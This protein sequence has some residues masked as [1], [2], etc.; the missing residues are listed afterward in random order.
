[1]NVGE[2]RPPCY[3]FVNCLQK[4]DLRE[5]GSDSLALILVLKCSTLSCYNI[6]IYLSVC[7]VVKGNIIMAKI[8]HWFFP[9]QIKSVNILTSCVFWFPYSHVNRHSHLGASHL[10]NSCP[11][12]R[13]S[14]TKCFPFV[15]RTSYDHLL[16]FRLLVIVSDG[17]K[18]SERTALASSIYM[19]ML[20]RLILGGNCTNRTH[21]LAG[22]RLNTTQVRSPTQVIAYSL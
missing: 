7:R 13:T 6:D 2:V 9:A 5:G 3:L 18:F 10:F 4:L 22:N 11:A 16:Q 17:A 19:Y 1:M 8:A 14:L 12:L 21:Y 15:Y 20:L